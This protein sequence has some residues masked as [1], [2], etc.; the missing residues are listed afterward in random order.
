MSLMVF[1]LATYL[2]GVLAG[3]WRTDGPPVMRVLLALLWPLG[4]LALAVTVTVLLAAS[5]VAFPV[6]GA[7]VAAGGAVLWWVVG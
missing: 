4:P 6:F 1:A 5:L 7:V 3:V 2:G